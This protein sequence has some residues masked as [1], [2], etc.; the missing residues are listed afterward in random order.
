MMT[1]KGERW[2]KPKDEWQDV[3]GKAWLSDL[4]LA[5]IIMMTE[6]AIMIILMTMDDRY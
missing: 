2:K 1:G 6:M 4:G 5:S 3:G